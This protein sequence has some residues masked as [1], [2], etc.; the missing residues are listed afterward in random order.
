MVKKGGRNRNYMKGAVEEI[1]DIGALAT[2]T[3][4]SGTM[5][6]VVTEK[7]LISSIVSTYAL[8]NWTPA[9]DDGPL[10]VGIAHSDYTDAEIEEVLENT[11]GWSQGN[12]VAQEVAKRK[13]RIIGTIDSH[14][15]D[16][17]VLNDGKPIKSKLN[18][19]LETGQTLKFWVYNS[20]PSA[21]TDG[22][23]L[24]M[25]GHVNLFGR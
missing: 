20:G 15:G 1:L 2:R 17:Q 22:A 9:P 21:L 11:G 7:T 14:D 13:V 23:D 19:L 12:L 24:T 6:S 18:W 5:S 16:V 3:L 10:T 4:V 8:S 25:V